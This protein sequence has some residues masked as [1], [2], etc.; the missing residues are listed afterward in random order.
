M[1]KFEVIIYAKENGYEPVTE[2]IDKQS[3]KMQARIVGNIFKLMEFENELREPY[4]KY[5]R[6]G[7]F[8][9]R[10]RQGSDGSRVLYFFVKGHSIVLTNAFTKKKIKL[11]SVKLSEQFA[12][13]KITW[14]GANNMRTF[15]EVSKEILSNPEVKKEY[16]A[17]QPEFEIMS[18]LIKARIENEMTQAKLSE[19]TGIDRANI[20]KLE[21]ASANPSLKTL[22]RIAKALNKQ[23]QVKFVEKSV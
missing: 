14:K 19:A 11:I 7:I 8:E 23:L 21:N 6:D 1:H 17:M 16:D 10:N 20:S 9:L 15:E 5:L 12:I 18:E 13:R 22:K 3:T 2:F 4:T